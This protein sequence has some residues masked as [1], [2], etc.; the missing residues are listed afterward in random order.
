MYTGVER[1]FTKFLELFTA[2]CD[3]LELQRSCGIGDCFFA[4]WGGLTSTRGLHRRDV[5]ALLAHLA[6]G[7]NAR[8]IC[9]GRHLCRSRLRP[10]DR[11]PTLYAVDQAVRHE[12]S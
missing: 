8:L 4:F 3:R 9:R 5:E 7:C 12:W 1:N 11:G 2:M 10:E 6:G